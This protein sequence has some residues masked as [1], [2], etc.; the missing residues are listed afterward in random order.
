MSARARSLLTQPGGAGG[1]RRR[2]SISSSSEALT[3]STLHARRRIEVA[4]ALEHLEAVD[5][6]HPQVEQH[7]VGPQPLDRVERRLAAVGF[8]DELEAVVE[9][10]RAAHAAPE[11]GTVVDD[12]D[13]D[14]AGAAGYVPQLT[15]SSRSSG[16]A[17]Q[18]I[19][20]R[21]PPR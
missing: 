8:A 18:S 20:P 9:P 19:R 16:I 12:Q 2:C 21:L 6:G 15:P 7:H 1:A 17:S 10:D 5:V 14:G 4:Q 11:H 13:A 3:I